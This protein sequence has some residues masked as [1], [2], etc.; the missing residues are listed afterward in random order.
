MIEQDKIDALK[1]VKEFQLKN[2]NPENFG[3]DTTIDI[4]LENQDKPAIRSFL[5]YAEKE[6]NKIF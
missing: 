6:S 4:A 5:E 3:L 2:V 1:L